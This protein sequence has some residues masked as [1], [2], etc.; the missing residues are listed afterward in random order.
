[1]SADRTAHGD[2]QAA[3]D[4]QTKTYGVR[5]ILWRMRPL[6]RPHRRR[7][8][9]ATACVAI[10]ATGVATMPL[11]AKI[12][13]DVVFPAK[14]MSW[15]LLA[16]GAFLLIG[17]VRLLAW[18]GAMRILLRVGEQVVFRMRQMG[19]RHL[20][21]L[22]MRF[23]SK[24]PSGFLYNR[25]FEQAICQLGMFLR[26]AFSTMLVYSLG[27]ILS[28]VVC[29][30]LSPPMTAVIFA[31]AAGYV[32]AA[33][34]LAPRIRQRT[35]QAADSHNWIAGF[36]LDRLRG[37]KTIQAY[38]MEDRVQD[39]FDSKVWPMQ[40]KWIAAQKESLSLQLI[41]ECLSYGITAAVWVVGA[42]AVFGWEMKLGTLVA[43]VGYQAQFTSSIASLTS[44][45][46]QS[47]AAR[48]GFDLF[49]SVLDTPSTVP[50]R[51]D[52]PMPPDLRGDLTFRDVTFCY[53][54]R[55]ALANVRF[56]IPHGQTVALVGRSGGGKTT[57]A[58]L[59][60][61]FYDPDEGAILVD[62]RD[63]REL[64]L[65]PYRALYGTVMQEPFLFN[66]TI[67][68][69]LRCARPDVTEEQLRT[70]L[71]RARA[72]EFVEEFPEGLG[73]Q[74]GEGGLG[75]SG[76]QRQRLSIARCML[77]DPKFL[78]LDEATSALDNE[79]ERMIQQALNALFEH[80]TAFVIAHRLSTIRRADR[81]LV[82]EK[83][84]IQED[85]T[86]DELLAGDGLFRYLYSI[87]TSTSTRQFKLEE[88]GFA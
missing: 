59:L 22:C 9:L 70:A 4:L 8:W 18:Y 10:S 21:R 75:L 19:F 67:A 88:A 40:E 53:D 13:I 76:G 83:G 35:R 74:V 39:D 3:E 37:T 55:P 34:K 14:V 28:L 77:L 87:A 30:T 56:E 64:P 48:A 45:Y 71:A 58:N 2:G 49:H 46:G 72:L 79:T 63:I 47:A 20:Q 51:A 1:M 41:T 65:R 15:A 24:Y 44:I 60:L 23:H 85:G 68:E 25:V 33:R 36:I 38:A 27:L 11:I 42:W 61:R 81:I 86:F 12:F 50:D 57:V 73:H 31:G 6:V 69:N 7:L 32:L 82:I 84:T 66:D 29:L 52:L 26:T 43:F 5:E 80:R 78:V 62:G 17:A 16:A 54:T